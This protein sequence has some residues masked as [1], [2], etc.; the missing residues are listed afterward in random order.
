MQLF[1]DLFTWKQNASSVIGQN[2]ALPEADQ[3]LFFCLVV[4]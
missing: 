2:L 3:G 4:D 1:I